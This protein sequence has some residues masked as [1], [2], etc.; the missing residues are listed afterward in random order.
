MA[1]KH[2][3]ALVAR[4]HPVL[5][6]TATAL[7]AGLLAL[8]LWSLMG[9]RPSHVLGMGEETLAAVLADAPELG[10][11]AL[12]AVLIGKAV[13]TGLTLGGG[14]SAGVLVPSMYLGGVSG[15][16]TAQLIALSGVVSVELDPALFAVVGIASALVAVIGVP[17]AAITLVL[18]V[19]GAAYGPPAILACGLTYLFTLRLSIYEAQRVS[20]TPGGDEKG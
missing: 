2:T 5:H 17:L 6:D 20:P 18:E 14:G 11:K 15:A 12:L 9:L 16:L 3:R 7:V 19:F 8:A 4:V 10:W 1:M 13:T